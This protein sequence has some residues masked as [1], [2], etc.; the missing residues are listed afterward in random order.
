MVTGT[1]AGPWHSDGNGNGNGD[2]VGERDG[3]WCE[4]GPGLKWTWQWDHRVADVR[5]HVLELEVV[6]EIVQVVAAQV[7]FE[8]KT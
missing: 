8:S 1:E 5:E 3:D 7:D 6:E 4:D 2:G